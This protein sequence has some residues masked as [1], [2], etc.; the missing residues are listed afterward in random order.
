MLYIV[1]L[2]ILVIGLSVYILI[3]LSKQDKVFFLKV[4][5]FLGAMGI[6]CAIITFYMK[7][8]FDL[9]MHLFFLFPFYGFLCWVFW[10]MY[11]LIKEALNEPENKNKVSS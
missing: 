4:V 9:Y 1:P 11:P 8:G 6:G 10:K 3:A 7:H 5:L 2:L